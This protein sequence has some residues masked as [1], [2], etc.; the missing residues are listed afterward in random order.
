MPRKG[1]YK[2]NLRDEKDLYMTWWLCLADNNFGMTM[3][4]MLNEMEEK[5]K[6][7]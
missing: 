4:N 2:Q 7:H 1:S 6:I 3:I 5:E